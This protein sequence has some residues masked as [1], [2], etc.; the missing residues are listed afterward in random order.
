MS[1]TDTEAQ[2][3]RSVRAAAALKA[4]GDEI[5]R[6]RDHLAKAQFRYIRMG[7]HAALDYHEKTHAAIMDLA[8]PLPGT[9]KMRR[10]DLLEKAGFH[11]LAA[12][13]I[14]EMIESL[15]ILPGT[16]PQSPERDLPSTPQDP[17]PNAPEPIS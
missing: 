15:R 12:C 13:D 9:T 1:T 17:T 2:D 7:M 4:A 11:D 14:R 10:T 3:E 6:L 5:E 16:E 8:E